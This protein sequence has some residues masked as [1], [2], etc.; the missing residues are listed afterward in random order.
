MLS[1]DNQALIQTRLQETMQVAQ[2]R[3]EQV[4]RNQPDLVSFYPWVKKLCDDILLRQKSLWMGDYLE[5]TRTAL[6]YNGHQIL[7]PNGSF[8][9]NIQRLRGNNHR[10]YVFNKLRPVSDTVTAAWTQAHPEVLFAVLEQMNRKA[11]R[12][13]WEIGDLNEY[14]NHLHFTEEIRQEIAQAGQFCGNYHGEVF[15]NKKAKYGSEWAEDWQHVQVPDQTMYQCLHPDC[16]QVGSLNDRLSSPLETLNYAE[17]KCPTCMSPV[18][19]WNEPGYQYP[20]KTGEGFRPSGDVGF[21]MV[22][23]W[24]MRYS[25]VTGPNLSPYRYVGQDVPKEVLEAEY[26]RLP[27]AA[28][29]DSWAIDEMM[30]PERILRRASRMD[31]SLDDDREAICKQR[32]WLQPDMLHFA[33]LKEPATLPSGEVLPAGTVLSERFKDGAL[34]TTA[35]GMPEFLDVEDDDH[36]LR[37]IDGRYGVTY[38]STVGHGIEDTVN[39]QKHYNVFRSGV[40]YYFNKFLIPSVAVDTRVFPDKKLFNRQD[41]II[42]TNVA[43]PDNVKVSDGYSIIQPPSLNGNIWNLLEA[44]QSDIKE[45]AQAF[46]SEGDYAGAANDTATAARIGLGKAS[47]MTNLHLSLFAGWMK[48]VAVRRLEVA[49]DNYGDK[50]MITVPAA[51]GDRSQRISRI[52]RSIHIRCSIMAWVKPG[53]YSPDLKLEKQE[54]TMARLNAQALLMKCGMDSPA[55]RRTL[56]EVFQSELGREST[57]SR[58]DACDDKLDDMIALYERMQ[59]MVEAVH[60]YEIYPVDPYEKDL[61]LR[62]DWW[63]EWLGTPEG[64]GAAL[65]IRQAVKMEIEALWQATLSQQ[66]SFTGAPLPGAIAGSPVGAGDAASPMLGLPPAT[67]PSGDST[68]GAAGAQPQA[69]LPNSME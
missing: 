59:G 50:R 45:G 37:F 54:S 25:R 40:A 55:N 1:V 22:P 39:N 35:P 41:P 67:N 19:L 63:Q 27:S 65:V 4:Q 16:G 20:Q 6:Y 10:L 12:A 33:K 28:T 61:D 30:M 23:A 3:P 32:F 68:G 57:A 43:M 51:H 64:R 44:Y 52:L 11:R 48:N 31:G 66:V 34:I 36:S 69:L 17:P 56:D 29:G 47:M 62:R 5:W 60:L 2:I 15:W 7:T 58:L 26:G 53:S 38:G 24:C 42:P 14:F 18:G 21:A 13:V 9:Y 8:G 46:D 49:R